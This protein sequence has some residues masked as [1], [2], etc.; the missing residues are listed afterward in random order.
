MKINSKVPLF[1]LLLLASVAT[2]S[3][4]QSS[5]F[6]YQGR[7]TDGGAP[8]KGPYQMQFTLFPSA[9]GGDPIGP[10]IQI[11]SVEVANGV[12]TVELNFT[13]PMPLTEARVGWG[14]R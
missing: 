8:A 6:T 7:L 9:V 4:A 14:S 12:F 10:T 13:A 11:D 1:V 2:R 3:A 5:S